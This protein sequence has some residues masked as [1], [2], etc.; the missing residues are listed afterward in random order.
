VIAYRDRREGFF[1][2]M[3]EFGATSQGEINQRLRLA[4]LGSGWGSSTVHTSVAIDQLHRPAVGAAVVFS[5]CPSV[6]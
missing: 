5:V 6:F 4:F 2:V 1:I 3:E